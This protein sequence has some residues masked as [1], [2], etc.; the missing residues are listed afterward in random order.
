M[1]I[2]KTLEELNAARWEDLTP[3]ERRYR[4]HIAFEEATREAKA[5]S[6]RN[7]GPDPESSADL[8]REMRAQRTREILERMGVIP[9]GDDEAWGA[10]AG[11]RRG[12]R[13][14]RLAPPRPRARRRTRAR[15]SRAQGGGASQR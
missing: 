13:R 4:D 1:T 5:I 10:S 7:G 9:E 8:I 14:H 6:A 11:A 3:E 2:K 12:A 15:R